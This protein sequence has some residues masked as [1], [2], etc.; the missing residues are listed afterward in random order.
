MTP[1]EDRLRKI[2]GSAI[3]PPRTP[4]QIVGADMI[5]ELGLTSID[6]LEILIHVEVEFGIQVHDEDLNQELV[7]SLPKLASYVQAR[8]D[9]K[10]VTP[11]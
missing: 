5:S 10:A 11:D 7:S 3:Q 1:I 4:D 8:L 9:A 2:I 6:A